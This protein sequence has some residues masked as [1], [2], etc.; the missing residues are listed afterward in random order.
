MSGWSREQLSIFHPAAG[1]TAAVGLGIPGPATAGDTACVCEARCS[2]HVGWSIQ[3][4]GF[5]I[6]VESPGIV[7]LC[8]PPTSPSVPPSPPLNLG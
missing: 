3:L 1:R 5:W 7:D 2:E 6:V 8:V 4:P